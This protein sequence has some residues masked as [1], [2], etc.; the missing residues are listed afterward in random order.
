M[1]LDDPYGSKP[2]GKQDQS[3]NIQGGPGLRVNDSLR[4]LMDEFLYESIQ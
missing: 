4:S 1:N 2:M 3:E